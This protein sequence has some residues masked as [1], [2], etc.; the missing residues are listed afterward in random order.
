MMK[1]LTLFFLLIGGMYACGPKSNSDQSQA[2]T[3][4]PA[5]K[6]TS[7]SASDFKD[8][9]DQN[10]GIILDVRTPQEVSQGKIAGAEV[11]DFY[12]PD[13]LNKV[14]ELP[15]DKE[16]YIYCSAGVRSAQAAEMLIQNGYTKVYQLQGGLGP[17]VNQGYPLSKD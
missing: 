13:F 12:Q 1:K 16:I 8:K 10:K 4:T 9:T 5:G 15:K 17:W 11:L 3:E 7:L 6:V 2:T 14:L